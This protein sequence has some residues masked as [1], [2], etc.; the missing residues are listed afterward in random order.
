M[1]YLR[2]GASALAALS[3]AAH[4]FSSPTAQRQTGSAHVVRCR[5][6]S[7]FSHNQMAAQTYSERAHDLYAEL[8]NFDAIMLQGTQQKQRYDRG[9]HCHEAWTFNRI[10]GHSV[11]SFRFNRIAGHSVYS[12]RTNPQEYKLP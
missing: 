7:F 4:G 1:P 3:S 6:I 8:S 5:D 11:Y 10:A 2:R 9:E 12:V